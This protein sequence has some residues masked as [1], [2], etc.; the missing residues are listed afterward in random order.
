MGYQ[1]IT[2]TINSYFYCFSVK[3]YYLSF[4]IHQW[5]RDDLYPLIEFQVQGLYLYV[6]ILI[7]ELLDSIDLF[8]FYK[9]RL[10]IP[11]NKI[12]NARC[13]PYHGTIL[14]ADLDKNIGFKKWFFHYFHP[15]A[16]FSSHFI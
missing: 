11:V 2:Q 12:D 1:H 14:I 10:T 4:L 6:F 16:P 9:S 13:H 15:V 5:S 8:F 7:Q 3:T